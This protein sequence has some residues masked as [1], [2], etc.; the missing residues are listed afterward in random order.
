[1][2]LSF[3][4][5]PSSEYSGLSSFKI[6]LFDLLAVQ[7][8]LKSL[9]QHHDLKAS[10]LQCPAFFMV[11][12]SHL[13]MTMAKTIALTRQTFVSKQLTF[14]IWWRVFISVKQL[15]KCASDTVIYSLGTFQRGAKAEDAGKAC[16]GKVHGVLLGSSSLFPKPSQPFLCN[17][18]LSPYNL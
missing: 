12:L 6:D 8:T 17:L 14:F 3:S 5:S 11:Q 9:L 7:G 13:Y 1:M 2:S 15:R 16:S 4:I 10:I 18:L